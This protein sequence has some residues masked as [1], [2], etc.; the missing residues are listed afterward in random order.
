VKV[1][2]RSA[3]HWAAFLQGKLRV[4]ELKA[5]QPSFSELELP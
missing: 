4:V 1:F 5:T 3:H 2:S